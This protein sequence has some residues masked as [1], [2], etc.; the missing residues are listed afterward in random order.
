MNPTA[1]KTNEVDFTIFYTNM[2]QYG[3]R[4]MEVGSNTVPRCCL[5][6]VYLPP[7]SCA[8]HSQHLKAKKAPLSVE[9]SEAAAEVF[10]FLLLFSEDAPM[11][12]VEMERSILNACFVVSKARHFAFLLSE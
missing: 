2:L 11:G 3:T 4:L 12:A 8:W 9:I 5:L 10:R 1:P 6:V 7:L